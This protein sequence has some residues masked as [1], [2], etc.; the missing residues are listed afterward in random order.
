MERRWREKVMTPFWGGSPEKKKG[1]AQ[2][3]PIEF[4]GGNEGALEAGKEERV[5][6]S[7]AY[8]TC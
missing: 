1:G 5:T 8:Q 4:K 2:K 3:R 6:G 7:G